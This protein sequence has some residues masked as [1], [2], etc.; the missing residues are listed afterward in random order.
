MLNL[1][2]FPFRREFHYSNFR[3]DP[4]QMDMTLFYFDIDEGSKGG[5]VLWLALPLIELF[6]AEFDFAF[7]YFLGMLDTN[8]HMRLEFK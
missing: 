4:I 2:P 5:Q 8:G 1:L 7:K 3:H 6:N